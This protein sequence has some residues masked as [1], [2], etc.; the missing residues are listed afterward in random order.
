M[1]MEQFYKAASARTGSANIQAL[2]HNP[3]R[4]LA[5]LSSYETSC[6]GEQNCIV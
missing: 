5:M 3:I 4:R 2:M 1:N 6:A